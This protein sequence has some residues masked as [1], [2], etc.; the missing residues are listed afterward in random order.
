MVWGSAFAILG[1]SQTVQPDNLIISLSGGG[2]LTTMYSN[3]DTLGTS[4][5]PS[6]AVRFTFAY[7]L[8]TRWSLGA[9][10]DR[11]GSVVHPG[12]VQYVRFTTY[13]IEGTYRPQIGRFSA[14]EAALAAGG[15]IMVLRPDELL[16]PYENRAFVYN[17]GIRYMHIVNASVGVY[18][19]LDHAQALNGTVT[20]RDEPLP[21]AAGGTVRIS[22]HN[23][24]ISAG[25]FVR[26]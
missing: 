10:Y 21:L 19:A 11:I 16:I 4:G 12:N 1:A 8:S 2:G 24:R 5:L 23:Q 22:W 14:V 18:I 20:Y 25:M 9:H 15:A 7:A 6:S 3:A 17:V 26:F 13:M